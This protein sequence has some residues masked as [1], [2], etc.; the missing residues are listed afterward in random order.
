MIACDVS[1]VAM[2]S[3]EAALMVFGY[4]A[5][6]HSVYMHIGSITSE[7]MVPLRTAKNYGTVLTRATF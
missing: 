2:F 1:P 5:M 7:R 3:F 4:A 6:L